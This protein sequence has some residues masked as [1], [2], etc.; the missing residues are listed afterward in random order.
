[1]AERGGRILTLEDAAVA[2]L[3]EPYRPPPLMPPAGGNRN[4]N[5]FAFIARVNTEDLGYALGNVEGG[6]KQKRGEFGYERLAVLLEH[7]FQL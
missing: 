4:V 1:M 7:M 2:R 5:V 6:C 3:P